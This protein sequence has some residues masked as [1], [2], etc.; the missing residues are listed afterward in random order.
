M[1]YEV[2]ITVFAPGA[3][4]SRTFA[5]T[6]EEAWDA[7]RAAEARDPCVLLVGRHEGN[8]NWG[9]FHL[10]L[11]GDR[12]LTRL[13]QHR[14][15]RAMDPARVASAAG[16]DTWFRDSDGT[17]F[18]AQHPETISRSQAFEALAFWLHTGDMLPALA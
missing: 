12:A 11:A 17:A 10:W 7:A 16:G 5:S 18:P 4:A 15:W 8:V 3:R 13:D 1:I 2:E 9:D 14:E 6:P